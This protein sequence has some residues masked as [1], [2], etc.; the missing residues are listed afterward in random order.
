MGL[1]SSPAS[2][3]CN[4][5][6]TSSLFFLF[7]LFSAHMTR[8]RHGE[9]ELEAIG[10]N[11]EGLSM[12]LAP[13]RV[14]EGELLMVDV[15]ESVAV[16]SLRVLSQSSWRWTRA[17]VALASPGISRQISCRRTRASDVPPFEADANG[18]ARRWPSDAFASLPPCCPQC[19]QR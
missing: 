17:S 14:L 5:L 6:P 12:S 3:F 1:S 18:Q 13:W 15:G 10:S 11:E 2:L 8:A 9:V 19:R 16:A 4:Q 7:S